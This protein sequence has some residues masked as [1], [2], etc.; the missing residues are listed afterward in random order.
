MLLP[1][2]IDEISD[3]ALKIMLVVV[4]INEKTGKIEESGSG[5]LS[6]ASALS[7]FFQIGGLLE[8]GERQLEDEEQWT[9]FGDHGLELLDRLSYQVYQLEIMDQKDN[10]AR[11]YTSL[12]VWLARRGAVLDNLEGAADGFALVVNGLQDTRELGEISGLMDEVLEKASET[13]IRDEDRS[14]A[15]RPWR[16]L[17]LNAGI[18]ATRSLD[19]AL[20]ERTFEKMVRRLPYD[21]P[22][23]FGDGQRNML[24]QD[25]P[26][27]V[28][29]VMERYAVKWPEKPAH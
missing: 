13:L 29:E 12:A 16:I 3:L 21:M 4:D 22:G 2:K 15:W 28:R 5:P 14:N 25:I 10:F 8:S 1:S 9:V 23:F 20:M 17:N 27:G 11:L 19:P 18:A 7:D 24:G 26:D 6:V